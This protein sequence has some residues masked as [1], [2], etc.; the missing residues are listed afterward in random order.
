M[1]T[2]FGSQAI[3]PTRSIPARAASIA[4]RDSDR[5]ILLV[6]APIAA[7]IV[8]SMAMGLG[9]IS[10]IAAIAAIGVAV[11][12]PMAG[13]AILGFMAALVP[14]AIPA[15]GF[16]ALLVG[17]ILL[18]CIY[19]L[20]VDRPR[21]RAGAPLVIL[22]AYVL[23][24]AAQQLPE[25]LGGYAGS[26]GHD[27]GF[28]FG[29][30]LTGFGTIVAAG[31][32]L[33]GRSPYPVL[34]MTL[35]GAG[36]AAFIAVA[37]FDQAVVGPPLAGLV[38]PSFDLG[39]ATGTFS[40]PNY[41]GTFAA[42]MAVAA[43]SLVSGHRSRSVRVGLAAIALLLFVAVGLS[44]SRGALFTVLG[45]LA[46]LLLYRNRIVAF[47][48]LGFGVLAMTLVYPAF[49]QWRLENL[50]GSA[51]A[52]SYLIMS[53]SDDGRLVGVL[54]APPLFLSSPITGI[55][56]GHF[57]PLSAFVTGGTQINAH[58]WYLTV[59]AEQGLV[60]IVLWCLLAIAVVR[61]LQTRV[62]IAK[63]VGFSVL[64]A[65]A[66]A[67]LFLEPPTSFQTIAA[68]LIVIVAALVGDW[69]QGPENALASAGS[70]TEPAAALDG[71]A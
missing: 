59:L 12:F 44:L 19:R 9:A 39:R 35:V 38:A 60:G 15:P 56:F 29:Q 54:A 46:V 18:G 23:F 51:S 65:L 70:T 48:T 1:A 49:V 61:E 58:N 69:G 21:V 31:Y 45:G 68:P 36:L 71:A 26:D 52:A 64:G 27:V 47:A 55:G 5:T 22:G 13:L 63:A 41:L 67:S 33:N 34:A 40:N 3:G 43:V 50:T 37:T 53:A 25:M 7:T 4:P 30:L 62:P 66:V 2:A 28:L 14:P 17:A 16:G 10:I 11:I 32:L 42:I 6:A 24:V 57:V 8:L 20:P